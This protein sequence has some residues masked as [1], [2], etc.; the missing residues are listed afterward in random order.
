MEKIMTE[1]TWS[2]FEGRL[3]EIIREELN[4]KTSDVL[5]T[6]DQA[7][8]FL[9]CSKTTLYYKMK[10]GEIPYSRLGKKLLFSKAALLAA[11]SAQSKK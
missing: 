7:C 11:I 3:R 2:F 1:F 10:S 9:S 8:D 5:L 4:G 6:R